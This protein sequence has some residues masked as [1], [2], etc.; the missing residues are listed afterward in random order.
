ME[1]ILIVVIFGVSCFL[2]GWKLRE[3]HAK[4]VV[5]RMKKEMLE[6]A[7]EEFKS[8]VVNIKVEDHNG[9]FFVYRKDDGS[10]LA[11]GETKSTLEDILNE[12]FPGKMF[13]ASPEDLQKL[14]SR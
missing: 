7:H 9:E 14:E 8:N 10:Y 5:A 13:N 11:H 4:N 1:P 3:I 12:K 6:E 2:L